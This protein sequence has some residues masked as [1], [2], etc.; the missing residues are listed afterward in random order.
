MPSFWNL[1]DM[2]NWADLLFS[3]KGTIKPQSFAIIVSAI[4]LLNIIAGSVLDGQFI[5]RVGPWPYLALQVIL[6]W[7][8]FTAHAKRLRDAGRGYVVAAVLAFI[9]LG[10]IV[11]VFNLVAA[12][13]ANI[14]GTVD[15]TEQ[16]VSLFG[17]I[18]AVLFINTLFT[19]DIVLIS[20]LLFVFIGL[21]LLFSLIVLIYSVVTGLRASLTPE[22]PAALPAAAPPPPPISASPPA[23]PVSKPRSPFS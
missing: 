16:K 6:T 22:T 18:F 19:G 1:P 3:P 5:K 7:I 21:P 2:M 8:W 14:S 11:L 10:T 13:T 15:Q 17:A 20:A 9:Y 23:A 12:S 4:Y